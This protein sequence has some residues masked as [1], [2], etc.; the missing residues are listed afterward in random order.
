[1]TYSTFY[2]KSWTPP[3][4]RLLKIGHCKTII[5]TIK[6]FEKNILYY[7]CDFPAFSNIFPTYFDIF[8]H[9]RHFDFMKSSDCRKYQRSP[10]GRGDLHFLSKYNFN[11]SY[12]RGFDNQQNFLITRIVVNIRQGDKGIIKG[13]RPW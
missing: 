7:I 3:L 2:N 11:K 8:R 4:Y 5:L 1:M 6:K 9:F 13:D 12:M 10:V